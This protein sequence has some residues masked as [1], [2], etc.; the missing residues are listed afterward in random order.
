MKP[1]RNEPCPCG[2]GKKYKR[3]CMDSISKQHA[4]MLDDIKQVAA[5]NPNLS[6]EELNI[7]A[8]QKMRAANERP[9]P[10]FCGL[11]PTQ[12]SNWLYASFKEVE[13]VTI[14]TPDDLRTS[15]VM[16]YLALILDEAMQ[17]DGSF[18][19]TSKGNLPTKIVRQANELLPEFA[20]SQFE[21]HISISEYAG[22]N[23]D[24]FNALHYSRILAEIAGIIYRRSG[25]YHVKKSAQKQYLNHGIQAF[26]TPMLEAATT[27]YNWGYLDGWEHDIDLRTVWL[28][29]LWRIQSHGNTEQ[30]IEEVITAF[31]DLLLRC[32]EDGYM[33]PSQLLGTMIESRF[34]KRF[35][36]FWGL[37][38]V[39]PFRHVNELRMSD[40]LETQPLMKLV[41]QFDV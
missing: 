37:V 26:F 6:L 36:E 1:G 14:H 4:S 7:V 16:R 35:L 2:S 33:S 27:Q 38:T 9:H 19:A 8:E 28:F 34:I 39:A 5:M 21:R 25:R 11:S 18:K 15:P 31:P 40:K 17:S 41:F 22:S 24:K 3:C 23:E 29:M 10:D 12:M 32:P 13:G 30:L 20:V